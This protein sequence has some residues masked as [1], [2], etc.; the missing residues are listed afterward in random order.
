MTPTQVRD[1]VRN[2]RCPCCNT[3]LRWLAGVGVEHPLDTPTQALVAYE[4]AIN[5]VRG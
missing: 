1:A 3:P 5:R 4:K 2:K